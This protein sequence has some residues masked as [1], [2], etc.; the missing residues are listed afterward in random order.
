MDEVCLNV[1][2]ALTLVTRSVCN[3][4]GFFMW[5]ATDYLRRYNYKQAGGVILLRLYL[6]LRY[7]FS[8]LFAF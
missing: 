6:L 2:Y 1:V 3:R 5:Q 4:P 7:F 8:S